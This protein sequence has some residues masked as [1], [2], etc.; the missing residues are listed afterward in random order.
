MKEETQQGIVIIC[1]GPEPTKMPTCPCS[2]SPCASLHPDNVPGLHFS[3][4]PSHQS[5]LQ[6]CSK[7][8][9]LQLCPCQ[10]WLVHWTSQADL[11]LDSLFHLLCPRNLLLPQPGPVQS[12]RAIPMLVSPWQQPGKVCTGTPQKSKKLAIQPE[13]WDLDKRQ[14]WKER[15]SK[16][17]SK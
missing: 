2:A 11:G 7:S 12:N 5:L 3:S 1:N 17:A 10:S 16:Q 6:Q 8:A 13:N 15:K 14:V 4:S 9:G